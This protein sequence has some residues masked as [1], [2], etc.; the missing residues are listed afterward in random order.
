MAALTPP[1]LRSFSRAVILAA[2]LLCALPLAALVLSMTA[3]DW[4]PAHTILGSLPRTLALTV[5]AAI[6][7][8]AIGSILAACCVQLADRA[9]LPFM[10]LLTMPVLLPTYVLALAWSVWLLPVLPLG[11][12]GASTIVTG[13]LPTLWVWTAALYPLPLWATFNALRRWNTAWT[14]AASTHGVSSWAITWLRVHY[15]LPP[16]GAA[17]LLVWMLTLSDFA[18]PDYFRLSVYGTEVFIEVSSYGNVPGAIVASLPCVAL[19]FL[20]MIGLSRLWRRWQLTA[21]ASECGMRISGP[22]PVRPGQPVGLRAVCVAIIGVALF[23]LVPISALVH[24]A[25]NFHGFLALWLTLWRD[26][27][28]STILAL[29]VVG[30]VVPITAM[31]GYFTQR[32]IARHSGI[33][34]ALL[35]STFAIPVAVLGLAGIA[36]WNRLGAVGVVYTSGAALVL[37]LIARWLPLAHELQHAGVRSVPAFLEEAAWTHGTSWFRAFRHI[38]LRNSR[39]S[40]LATAVLVFVLAFNDLT[41]AALLAPPGWSTLP[42]RVFSTIHY[43][44]A[45]TLA[46]ICLWQLLFLLMPL[47]A[48]AWLS[49][50]AVARL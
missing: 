35:A 4:S 31:T 42:L 11:Q 37:L 23:V 44:S 29:A 28:L 13:A 39:S 9:R 24:A 32:G 21:A 45:S 47:T 38:V 36:L 16:V 12:G 26:A 10:L 15:L 7:T 17:T 40:L 5:A 19:A 3:Q 6:S 43:G 22:V 34:R 14:E 27:L 50:R 18:V 41:L 2:L 8:S 1:W 30:V 25:A 33:V 20:G 48:L 49:R 46:S